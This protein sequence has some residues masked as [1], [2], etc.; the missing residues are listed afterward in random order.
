VKAWTVATAFSASPASA[1]EDDRQDHQRY[2]DQAQRRELGTG[3]DHQRDGAYAHDQVAQGKGGGRA[4]DDLDQRGV[5]G[6]TR[7]HFA[8]ARRL[9]E[10]GAQ[11]E[12]VAE[13][14]G[15]HI[16]GDALAD[17]GDE[18]EA[19]RGGRA[20]NAGNSDE[21]EEILPDASRILGREAVI[22]DAAHRHGQGERCAGSD[23]KGNTGGGDHAAIGHDEGL[24]RPER[25][26]SLGFLAALG[27]ALDFVDNLRGALSHG[28]R[29][30]LRGP[31][32]RHGETRLTP[33]P[34]FRR[35]EAVS[36]QQGL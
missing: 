3:D 18:V 23:D 7:Q 1:E 5:R 28:R 21:H 27:L 35:I 6:E 36:R 24:E 11:G 32:V 8:G 17:P 19:G 20:H 10:I 33:Q 9:E 25:R 4:D 15:A 26:E 16:G 29:Y 22:D 2:A 14:T 31:A 34:Q 30:S 13:D 12:D